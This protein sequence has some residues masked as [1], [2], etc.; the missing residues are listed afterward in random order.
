M[1][2]VQ[3]SGAIP[4]GVP[5]TPP[6]PGA[7]TAAVDPILATITARFVDGPH[8]GFSE[9]VGAGLA[10]F[11]RRLAALGATE[12]E[13]SPAKPA[14]VQ[15]EALP[16]PSPASAAPVASP[17]RLLEDMANWLHSPPPGIGGRERA[18][19]RAMD[20]KARAVEIPTADA[21]VPRR[22]GSS[23]PVQVGAP[24]FEDAGAMAAAIAAWMTTHS[25]ASPAMAPEVPP[26]PS[27]SAPPEHGHARG[28]ART[29]PTPDPTAV[30][31]PVPVLA[32]PVP[33]VPVLRASAEWA[34]PD[35][36]DA[37]AVAAPVNASH[38]RTSEVTGDTSDSPAPRSATADADADGD[39]HPAAAAPAPDFFHALSERPAP[40]PI[41]TRTPAMTTRP[42][43]PA[44]PGTP[45]G[46][47]LLTGRSRDA[48]L[49]RII[50]SLGDAVRSAASVAQDPLARVAIPRAPVPQALRTSTAESLA[51]PSVPE[52][53][54]S[55]VAGVS[56][57]A[58]PVPAQQAE[59]PADGRH[60]EPETLLNAAA[61]ATGPTVGEVSSGFAGPGDAPL[62]PTAGHVHAREATFALGDGKPAPMGQPQPIHADPVATPR[63]VERTVGEDLRSAHWAKAVAGHLVELSHDQVDNATLRLSPEHLGPIEVHIHLQDNVVN[64]NFGATHADTRSTLEQA[65]PTL[66]EAFAGAGL[67]LG[68]ATVQQEMRQGSQDR[69]VMAQGPVGTADELSVNSEV[70]RVLSLVDE[71]A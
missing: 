23:A 48:D 71:Y 52:A 40:E 20:P 13:A 24:P 19:A 37:S 8:Y 14:E 30:T 22:E 47:T 63:S 34:A 2:S 45:T 60:P 15:T 38:A 39:S 57:S 43:G 62:T 36:P 12:S 27:D 58:V 61:V 4:A 35:R 21:S 31:S 70:R 68:Q 25:T 44:A 32:A 33:E 5:G 9:G 66:R 10:P 16:L 69:Q 7:T 26:T 59:V 3:R 11:A 50:A 67:S 54:D 53:A 49:R 18:A 29:A 1:I 55:P 17:E 6:T 64:L 46:G 51:D 56:V 28:R 65:M 41:R 42:R